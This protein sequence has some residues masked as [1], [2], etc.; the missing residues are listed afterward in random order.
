M[1]N[2]LVTRFSRTSSS[3]RD[4][5]GNVIEIEAE[6]GENEQSPYCNCWIRALVD[7]VSMLVKEGGADGRL[8]HLLTQRYALVPISIFVSYFLSLAN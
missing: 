2:D 6:A 4:P 1:C 8:F 5:I 3:F 7:G